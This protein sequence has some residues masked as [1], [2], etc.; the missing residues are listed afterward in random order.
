MSDA[1][2]QANHTQVTTKLEPS[3][4]LVDIKPDTGILEPPCQALAADRKA[5]VAGNVFYF[6]QGPVN[7]DVK[8]DLAGRAEYL[9]M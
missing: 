1:M 6:G 4:N 9:R 2:P 7:E 8:P 3:A 5:I